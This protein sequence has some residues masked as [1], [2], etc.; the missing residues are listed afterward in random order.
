[1]YSASFPVFWNQVIDYINR[2]ENQPT[3]RNLRTG[4]YLNLPTKSN[5]TTPNW[6]SLNAGS[7]LLDEVGFYTAYL[8]H[9]EERF[10]ASLLNE[11]ESNVTLGDVSEEEGVIGILIEEMEETK[12]QYYWVVASLILLFLFIEAYVYVGRGML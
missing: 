7:V 12:R 6:E 9:G 3:R 5:V 2:E 8:E 11:L 1:H 10:S 4:D